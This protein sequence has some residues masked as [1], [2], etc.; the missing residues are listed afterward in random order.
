MSKHWVLT[1]F[2]KRSVEPLY[3]YGEGNYGLSAVKEIDVTKGFQNL[4]E[5][6]KECQSF[7][8]LKKCFK[9]EFFKRGYAKCQCTPFHL[10]DYFLKI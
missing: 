3:I 1:K 4:D 8:S 7:E 5:R 6:I 10:R 9:K 2:I